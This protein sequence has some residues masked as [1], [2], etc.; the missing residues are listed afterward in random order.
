MV[1][2]KDRTVLVLVT[3]VGTVKALLMKLETQALQTRYHYFFRG[4]GSGQFLEAQT[5]FFS[6]LGCA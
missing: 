2:L 1:G 4:E 6:P 3:E 5:F